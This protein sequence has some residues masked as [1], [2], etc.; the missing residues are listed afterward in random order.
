MAKDDNKKNQQAETGMFGLENIMKSFYD[1]QPSSDDEYGNYMKNTFASNMIQSAFD[2]QNAKDVAYTQ[3]EI[4]SGQ[5]T[6]AADLQ[7]LN[8]ES[9]MAKEYGY[10]TEMMKQQFDYQSEF[11]DDQHSRDLGMVGAMGKEQRKTEKSQQ[12]SN[13]KIASGRYKTDRVVAN[14]QLAGTKYT[15]NKQLKGTKYTANKQLAG[16]KDT[17]RFNLKGTKYTADSQLAGVKDTN[18]ANVNIAGI[19]KESAL[20]VAGIQAG[21]SNYAADQQLSG[22]RDTNQANVNIAGKQLEGTKYT[23]DSNVKMTDMSS[24]RQLKGTMYSADRS[25]ES[26]LG[27]ADRQLEGTKYG[28]DK[29]LEGIKDTNLTSTTNIR[30]TGDET[31][32]TADNQQRLSAKERADMHGYARRTARAS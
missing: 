22:V 5:M 17:N 30:V 12:K 9:I 20:G 10:G 27:V 23:A 31:R 24:S 8:T 21:A 4:S 29:N 1:Y 26:A 18:K 13:E 15:A 2:T 28:A 14:K 3:S 19:N 7:R 11:A 6:Q 25:K 16:I 32:K